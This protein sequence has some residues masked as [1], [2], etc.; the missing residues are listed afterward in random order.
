[1]KLKFYSTALMF[2]LLG[3]GTS[4]TVQGQNIKK[5]QNTTIKADFSKKGLQLSPDMYGLFFEDINHAAD[6][7]LY[8]ELI[9][10]RDFEYGKTPEGM[11]FDNDSTVANPAGWK[12]FY[13]KPSN[14]FGWMEEKQAGGAGVL[15]IEET[16]PVNAANAHYLKINKTK[17]EGFFGVSN[18]GFWGISAING[19][20]YQLSFYAKALKGFGGA[21]TFT[22]TNST[23][24]ILASQEVKGIKGEW[25]KL[26]ASLKSTGTDA[27]SKLVVTIKDKGAVCLDLISLFPEKTWKNHGMRSDLAQLLADMK[28]SFLRFPGGCVVEG[29]SLENRIQWKNTIGDLISRPGRWNIWGYHTTE[30]LGHHEYL[31]L[32]EDL[33]VQPMYVV[34]V[35]MTCQFRNGTTSGF[36]KTQEYLQEA[37]DGI[38]Y[39]NGPI[40]SKWGAM[41]AKNGHPAPF[42]IKYVEIGNENNGP[43]YQEVYKIFQTAIKAKYPDIITIANEFVPINDRDYAKHP[44][45]GIEMVDEHYYESP[46]F[47]YENVT[48]Y[49]NYNRANS[50][51]IYVGE[52]AVTKG[53]EGKGSLRAA[54]GEAA[55]M[56]GMERNADIV[57]MTSYAPTFVNVHDRAWNPNM[58]V[59]NSSQSF[60]TPS[61]YALKM[62]SENRPDEVIPTMVESPKDS[63]A[64]SANSWK[65][66]VGGFTLGAW[67]TEVEYKD[68]KVEKDGQT[69][70][71]DDFSAGNSK[72]TAKQ[73]RWEI[74]DGTYRNA[75]TTTEAVT[76]AGKADWTNYTLSLKARKIK[77][78]EG[79]LIRLL[80][81]E[82]NH[83]T[84]NL[85]GW[86]NS[87]HVVQQSVDGNIFDLGNRIPASIE[88]G[89]WYDLRIEIKDRNVK[90]FLDGKLQ[91][92][93]VLR[94]RFVP[95]VYATTGVKANGEV[96]LKIVN[97]L[98]IAKNCQIELSN[99]GTVESTGELTVLT[100]GNQSDEN[101]FEQPLRISPKTTKLDQIGKVFNYTCPPG[102][103]SIIKLKKK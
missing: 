83:L 85:G 75:N 51:K 80:T 42:N 101:S 33:G 56:L 5:E 6:G 31:Q 24:K 62:F 81:N 52:F 69:I 10:N 15:S 64:A 70:F 38:E 59:Y 49:D 8:A 67:N 98:E 2:A 50:P 25:K 86:N 77:G 21:L 95:S 96:I 68:V 30:G 11:S 84:W 9:E 3:L 12:N 54:L 13:R 4:S 72:W 79:F 100:S 23:G 89:K 73:D 22:L 102:S 82:N 61:Y 17:K 60:G 41:R 48:K 1:M 92:E 36:D 26:T 28:P 57:K 87:V 34:N 93:E 66:L 99:I 44:N 76:A 103:I 97:P 27:N 32:C 35:G 58:L 94:G 91:R 7:G 37:L 46:N 53:G 74:K 14:M 18:D 65:H 16:Q 29:A 40:T 39:A 20:I 55:F 45:V 71:S 19:E 47:F 88:T 78:N 43:F 63:L 90:F